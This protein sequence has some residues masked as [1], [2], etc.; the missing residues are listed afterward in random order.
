MFAK[1]KILS[2]SLLLAIPLAT[3]AIERASLLPTDA[4][5]YVRVSNTT[6]FWSKLQQSSIGKLWA[7]QQFQDFLGN[8]EAETWQEVFFEGESEAE[9][10]SSNGV[11]IDQLIWSGCGVNCGGRRGRRSPGEG[12]PKAP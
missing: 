3:T 8:P 7:D 9:D 1:L 6:N 2:L 4:Q 11:D 10:D 5:T 12:I